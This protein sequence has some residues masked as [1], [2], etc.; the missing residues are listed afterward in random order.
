MRRHAIAAVLVALTLTSCG[1]PSMPRATSRELRTDVAAIRQAVEDGRKVLARQRLD[2]LAGTVGQLLD[3]GVIDPAAAGDIL[4]SIDL[5]R[6]ALPSMPA[7]SPSVAPTTT[8]PPV[9]EDD[10]GGGNGNAYGKDK[11]KDDGGGNG[12]Q[13]HGNDD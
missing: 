3:E 6:A 8:P 5:V 9:D 1:D 12:N 2:A 10:E 7:P 4:E 11:D 13:G